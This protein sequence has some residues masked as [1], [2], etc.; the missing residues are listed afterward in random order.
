MALWSLGALNNYTR[1]LPLQDGLIIPDR[2]IKAPLLEA[3]RPHMNSREFLPGNQVQILI[4]ELNLL[5]GG[6]TTEN[7]AIRTPQAGSYS[8]LTAPLREIEVNVGTTMQ[9]L[10]RAE[11]MPGSWGK[12][13]DDLLA[14]RRA[15]YDFTWDRILMNAGTGLLANVVSSSWNTDTLTVTCDNTY[16][17]TGVENVALIKRGMMVEV[18]AHGGALVADNASVTS[19]QVQASTFGD[20]NN[21]AATTGSFTIKPSSDISA[22]VTDADFVYA[23]G[24]ATATG[25]TFPEPMGL[26]AHI[27]GTG[28][29]YA[30]V[31]KLTTYQGVTRASYASTNAL[32]WQA[33]DFD[34]DGS[35]GTPSDWTLRTISRFLNTLGRGSGQDTPDLLLASSMLA[36]SIMDRQRSE[37]GSNV[38]V[39]NTRQEAEQARTVV[40]DRFAG[41]F[42]RPDGVMIPIRVAD[43]IPATVLYAIKTGAY[44]WHTQGGFINLASRLGLGD[45]WMKSPAD[46]LTN[47]EAPGHEYGQITSLRNDRSGCIQDMLAD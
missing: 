14:E 44:I 11:G 8:L 25:L 46:R 30:G 35:D 21:G 40:G 38:V 31:N 20:R 45:V 26:V 17:Q 16:T 42:L 4:R 5:S 3:L 41:Q 43:T 12:H 34:S 9:A 10:D 2:I 33:T 32:V 19:W 15:D 22:N 27:Q 28:D 18:L 39:Y 23:K 24:T 6:A 7:V 1:S 29:G 13:V 36:M 47:F 37:G